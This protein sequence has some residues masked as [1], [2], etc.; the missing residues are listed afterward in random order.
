[1]TEAVRL[2]KVCKS[3]NGKSV[4]KD[5]CLQVS[6]GKVFCLSGPNGSGKTTVLN[7]IAGRMKLDSGSVFVKGKP[8]YC[9][10][11]PRLFDDLTVRENLEVFSQLVN[12]GKEEAERIS[13]LAGLAEFDEKRV[14]ELSTGMRKRVELAVSMLGSPQVLLLDEPTTGLDKES[15]GHVI[16]VL[17]KL[18]GKKTLLIATH[19]LDDFRGVVDGKIEV[20]KK[21]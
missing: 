16:N 1:M 19:Q 21:K 6:F 12:A 4:L 11:E 7:I 2:E 5:F 3:F 17:K 15:V 18:K 14:G 8:G 13:G 20:K 9:H 10:Q